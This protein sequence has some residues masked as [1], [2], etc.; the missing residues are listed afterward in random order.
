MINTIFYF[1]DTQAEYLDNWQ[2]GEV[3]PHTI[4]FAKDTKTIW[5]NGMRFSG[6]R[7]DEVDDEIHQLTDEAINDLNE[8]VQNLEFGLNTAVQAA[9]QEKIR[10]NGEISRIDGAVATVASNLT[11]TAAAI[12]N[13]VRNGELYTS[14][15]WDPKINAYLKTVGLWDYGTGDTEHVTKWSQLRQSVDGVSSEVNRVE[16]KADGYNNTLQ[17]KIN[18]EVTDRGEAVTTL[19]NTFARSTEDLQGVIEWMYSGLHSGASADMSYAE[20]IAAGKNGASSAI[21]DLRT[22]IETTSDGK[23]VAQSSL[24]SSVDR[25]ISGIVNDV[26]GKYANT[27]VF[28]QID[29]NSYNIAAIN[30]FIGPDMAQSTLAA[31]LNKAE[32]G[33]VATVKDDLASMHILSKSGDDYT[34]DVYTKAE[35]K[36]EIKSAT[37]GMATTDDLQRSMGLVY[38]KTE[39]DRNSLISEA[40][41]VT[42]NEFT[43][44]SIIAKVNGASSSV[45]INADHINIDANHQLDLSA[46]SIT[47]DADDINLVGQTN[48]ENAIGNMI[49]TKSLKISDV[50]NQI[51]TVIESGN[52][53]FSGDVKASTLTAGPEQGMH[54]V[55]TGNE[56]HFINGDTIMG[57][58]VI[59]DDGLQMYILGPD[60]DLYK[61]NF[62]NW[63]N[64]SGGGTSNTYKLYR[65][66]QSASSSFSNITNHTSVYGNGDDVYYNDQSGKH[67]ANLGS[68]SQTNAFLEWVGVCDSVIL[69][70]IQYN[71]SLSPDQSTPGITNVMYQVDMYRDVYFVDGIK[72]YGPNQYAITKSGTTDRIYF[73]KSSTSK[74]G[75]YA[76]NVYTSESAGATSCADIPYINFGN[77][78]VYYATTTI[79]LT[80]YGSGHMT[81]VQG[82]SSGGTLV[83]Y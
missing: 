22:S 39:A 50:N 46:Q 51:T 25:A 8:G 64:T 53:T 7:Q 57:K 63:T 75:V 31:K 80:P 72:H 27:S 41:L 2:K 36:G 44:A 10:L 47:I 33:A 34:A 30:T 71:S 62:N 67:L 58:F 65:F 13:E 20:I 66:T 45:K 70:N 49:T 48:F 73:V 21:S 1:A 17:S 23:Y 29:T 77:G 26:T 5:R 69:P 35:T 14:E 11:A 42:E 55:T 56:I 60:G 38:T 61:V 9:A 79:S 81:G 78:E 82:E 12:R 16:A 54:I 83:T 6:L 74:H 68:S 19:S 76:S 40:G 43:A 15:G 37:T 3:K 52:A 32:A 4:C 24:T 59:E 28:S 18:Q